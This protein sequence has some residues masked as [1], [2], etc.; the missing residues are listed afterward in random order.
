MATVH[1]EAGQDNIVGAQI[2]RDNLRLSKLEAAP[3]WSARP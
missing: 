1:T 3:H 2:H